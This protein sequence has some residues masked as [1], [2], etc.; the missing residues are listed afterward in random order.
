MTLEDV[1]LAI[2]TRV[3]GWTDAPLAF[4]NLPTP[5]AVTTAQQNSTPWVRVTINDGAGIL[6]NLNDDVART[7]LVSLQVFSAEDV[8]DRPARVIASSLCAHLEHYRAGGLRLRQAN[9]SRTGKADG[10][11]Q[12]NVSI[13]F[14]AD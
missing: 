2:I 4:D 6:R 14:V 5:P 9:P 13:P 12:I 7:G 11:Y 3:A 10:Y 1:R 8:G